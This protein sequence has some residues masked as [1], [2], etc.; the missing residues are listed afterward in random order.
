MIVRICRLV[1]MKQMTSTSYN[2]FSVNAQNTLSIQPLTNIPTER[3]IYYRK[4]IL[5][6]TQPSQYRFAKLQCRYAVTSGSPSI[7]SYTAYTY[8]GNPEARPRILYTRCRHTHN[9]AHKL[10]H[11][12]TCTHHRAGNQKNVQKCNLNKIN[13]TLTLNCLDPSCKR[14]FLQNN[15]VQNKVIFFV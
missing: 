4:Q 1:H 3:S 14:L 12:Q 10:A 13:P 2:S 6:I 15:L 7:F 9:V 8:I 5:Q 11:N